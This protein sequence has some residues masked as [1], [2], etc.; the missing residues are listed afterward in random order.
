MEA[1]LIYDLKV[2]ALIATFYLFWRLLLA[3]ETLHRL[4]RAVLLTTAVLS[5]VLPLCV[6]TFHRSVLIAQPTTATAPP[7]P[8]TVE[9]AAETTPW[10]LVAATVVFVA[11]AVLT[12]GHALLSMVRVVLLIRNC[13]HHRQADGTVVAVCNRELSPFSYFHYIVMSRSDYN[14]PD[15]AIMAHERA[16]ISARHSWDILLVSVLTVLQWFN[17]ALWLLR[18]DL[19]TIHEFEADA[20]VLSQGIDVRQYQ[21]LLVKKAVATHGYFV[22]NSLSHS[23]LK[24]R[25]NMMIRK[26]TNPRQWLRALYIV[27]VVAVSIAVSARTVTDYHMADTPE[28]TYD[29]S[30][31]SENSQPPSPSMKTTAAETAVTGNDTIADNDYERIKIVNPGGVKWDDETIAENKNGVRPLVLVN[32]TE[33][34]YESFVK[35]SPK[36]IKS[37]TVLKDKASTEKYGEKAKDGVVIVE[38]EDHPNQKG[39]E[40]MTVRGQVV[41]EN[42]KPVIGAVV[43]ILGT[44]QGTVTDT[45]G[46]FNI[47]APDGATIEVMYVGMGTAT[48]VTDRKTMASDRGNKQRTTVIMKADGSDVEKTTEVKKANVEVF[49]NGQSMGLEEMGKKLSPEEIEAISIDKS[50]PSHIKMNVTLKKK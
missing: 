18:S 23:T 7:V 49:V 22:A 19:R 3:R 36:I 8:A 31:V 11:G 24:R 42:R 16:H 13:E 6:V 1:F 45:D 4:N 2:A 15:A 46:N 41:D 33:M 26:K 17:P 27:P 38:I 5:F 30:T 35:I 29:Y 50:N 37:I 10:L 20:A 39:H 25:I 43:K 21:Y 9:T 32:G 40:P 48:F 34:P 12:L 28:T 44:K 14:H 47:E